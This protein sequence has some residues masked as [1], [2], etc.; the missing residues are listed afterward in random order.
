MAR[1][2]NGR[3]KPARPCANHHNVVLAAVRDLR[4]CAGKPT[5]LRRKGLAAFRRNIAEVCREQ[6]R[7][8]P[9]E[10][11]GEIDKRDRHPASRKREVARILPAPTVLL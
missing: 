9:R 11:S 10:T 7:I 1:R 6:H 3:P 4:V 5:P 8:A 2:R